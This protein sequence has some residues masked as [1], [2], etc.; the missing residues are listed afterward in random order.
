MELEV[1]FILEAINVDRIFPDEKY[2]EPVIKDSILCVVIVGLP[3]L[4]LTIKLLLG[5]N[6][7]AL[8]IKVI[9]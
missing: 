2:Y 7:L 6:V 1:V 9:L 4:H 3:T 8:C 5:Y